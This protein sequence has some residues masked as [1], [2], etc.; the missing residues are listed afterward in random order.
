MYNNKLSILFKEF[1]LFL[2][3]GFTYFIIEIL[4]RGYSHVSMFILGGICFIIIGCLNEFYTWDMSLISQMFLSSI[5]ITILEFITGI[6][7]NKVLCLNVWDYTNQPYN[8]YGQICL[9]F[10]NLWFFLSLAGIILDDYIRYL[11]F[12]EEKSKYKIF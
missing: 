8:L 12:H 6:I 2:V 5:F 4:F 11:F 7:V 3:G 9:L 1:I 10:T